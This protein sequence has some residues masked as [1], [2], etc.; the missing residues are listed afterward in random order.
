MRVLMFF[1]GIVACSAAVAG[2]GVKTLEGEHVPHYV[3]DAM[4]LNAEF[5]PNNWL[6]Y[7]R[8][9]QSTRYSPL[10][11]IDQD[12]IDDLVPKW[13]LSFG[14]IGAQDGQVVAVN[15]M[16]YVTSSHN[17]VF[18]LDGRTG[19]ILWKYERQLPGDLGPKLCCGAV[20]RGVAVY[21][22][23]VYLATLDTHVLALDNQTGEIVWDKKLG[24]Y[25]TGEIFTSMPVALKGKIIVGNSGGDLGANRGRIIAL[26][27]E[28]GEVAWE[29]FTI[30]GPGEPGNDTW[31]GDSWKLGGGAP[32]LPG[33]YDQETGLLLWG[34]GNAVPDFDGS[35]RPGDNLYTNS[36]LA[37]DPE[38]GEI[39]WHFQYTPHGTWDYDGNNELILITDEKGRKVYLHGDRNGYLYSI[40]RTTGECVWVEPLVPTNWVESFDENCRPKVNEAK[41]PKY[42]EVT[43]D[44]KPILGGG[45]EWIPGAYSKR[46]GL[47]YMPVRNMSMDLAAKKQEFEPGQWFLSTEVLRLNPGN[48]AVKAFNATTGELTW[49]RAQNTPATSGLLATAGGLVFSGDAEGNFMALDDKTGETLWMYDVGTGIHSMPTTYMVGDT[50]YVA[51]LAGPGG[52]S[53]WPLVYGE[54]FKKHNQGGGLFIFALHKK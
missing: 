30:P 21:H 41:R 18:K 34:V 12:N 35:V 43:K 5:D 19:D 25:K 52:G 7:G 4:L 53:L 2:L 16:L 40:D 38:T 33:S 10:T 44:I 6:L 14:V 36:T 20:N 1:A 13:H 11:Q 23:K 9:Y 29:T 8:D 26:D 17:K 22:D 37:L 15:G 39:K 31:G 3:T 50:Q 28:T 48:G 42:G 24:D 47:V 27:A 49:M 32:W 45:K 46:T 51:V 54:W